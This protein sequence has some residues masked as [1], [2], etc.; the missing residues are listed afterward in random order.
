MSEYI[1]SF[2]WLEPKPPKKN[3][4]NPLPMFGLRYVEPELPKVDGM[5]WGE[6]ITSESGIV[7]KFEDYRKYTELG[8]TAWYDEIFGDLKQLTFYRR[9]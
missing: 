8:M 2:L 7:L 6:N 9:N 3:H 4:K 5:L 1:R